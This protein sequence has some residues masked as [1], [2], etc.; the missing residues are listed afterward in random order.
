MHNTNSRCRL[1][2]LYNISS[3]F[4]SFFFL[5]RAVIV[6]HSLH[7]PIYNS[8][9]PLFIGPDYKGASKRSILMNDHSPSHLRELRD[10]LKV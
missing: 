9:P 1:F 6:I 8:I 3:S 5:V 4:N 7:D 10:Y 2:Q